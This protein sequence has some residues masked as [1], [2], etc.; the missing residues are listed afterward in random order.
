MVDDEEERERH[1][2]KCQLSYSGSA[3]SGKTGQAIP[4]NQ[5]DKLR[6]E[7]STTFSYQHRRTYPWNSSASRMNSQI[8]EK[9]TKQGSVGTRRRTVPTAIA[10]WQLR[11]GASLLAAVDVGDGAIN[12]GAGIV[13]V[14]VR[15]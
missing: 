3:G 15:V 6:T 5:I 12:G 8:E 13:E 2:E 14:E 1:R 11:N 7:Q 10:R 4:N 9:S